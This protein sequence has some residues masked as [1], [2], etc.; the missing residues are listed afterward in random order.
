MSY[1]IISNI[2]KDKEYKFSY[3]FSTIVGSSGSS[4]LTLKNSV[5]SIHTDKS[6]INKFH[7]PIKDFINQ[8]YYYYKNNDKK[9]IDYKINEIFF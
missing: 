7:F 6:L 2:F 4:I 3:K 9:I 5:I 8:Y 1:G